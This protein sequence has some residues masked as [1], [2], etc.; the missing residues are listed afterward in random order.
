MKNAAFGGIFFVPCSSEFAI[1]WG[2]IWG[3]AIPFYGAKI[4]NFLE[5][6]KGKA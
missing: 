4:S 3:F 2:W 6:C 5:K 1:R